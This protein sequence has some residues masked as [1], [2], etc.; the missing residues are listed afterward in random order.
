MFVSVD[1]TGCG[2]AE[3]PS[4]ALRSPSDASAH[5]SRRSFVGRRV[6]TMGSLGVFGVGDASSQSDAWSCRHS[7]ANALE[8]SR[9]ASIGDITCRGLHAFGVDERA[10]TGVPC[11]LLIS[12]PRFSLPFTLSPYPGL[13]ARSS[14]L[15]HDEPH[16]RV[17]L[18]GSPC[19]VWR[20][21]LLPTTRTCPWP[22]WVMVCGQ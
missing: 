10:T 18:G 13:A 8:V 4:S 2:D 20:P 3:R 19:W 7:P 12:G 15:A 21:C 22:W 5:D 6:G 9:F 16:S 14:V 1:T 11:G 17:S